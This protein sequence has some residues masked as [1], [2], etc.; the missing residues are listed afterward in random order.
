MK[1]R[2]LIQEKGGAVHTVEPSATVAEAA[3]ILLD[4]DIGSLLITED[5]RATGIFTKNDLLR[6]YLEDPAGFGSASVVNPAARE[7]Y[8]TTLDASLGEV[9]GEMIRRGIR[10]VPVLDGGRPAGMITPID[11][12]VHLKEA[13]HYENEQLRKYIYGGA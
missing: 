7:L 4:R 13:V 10:H 2:D 8:S 6:R 11:V 5:G 3:R 9:F 12:L 1:V